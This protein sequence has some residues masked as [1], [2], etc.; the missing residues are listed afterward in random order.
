MA[1]WKEPLTFMLSGIISDYWL[2]GWGRIG[3]DSTHQSGCSKILRWNESTLVRIIT[4]V[5]KFMVREIIDDY[6]YYPV[7]LSA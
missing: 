3:L 6:Y 5:L 4:R 2:G 1:R 7:F